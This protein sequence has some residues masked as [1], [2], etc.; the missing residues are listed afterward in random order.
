MPKLRNL[1]VPLVVLCGLI[2]V[3][4]WAVVELDDRGRATQY[5]KAQGQLDTLVTF[6]LRR[7]GR[8]VKLAYGVW[9]GIESIRAEADLSDDP[10]ALFIAQSEPFIRRFMSVFPSVEQ[11]QIADM[12]GDPMLNIFLDAN[13][14][15]RIENTF[16]EPLEPAFLTK[17]I[18]AGVNDT[19]IEGIRARALPSHPDAVFS[20]VLRI[21]AVV[22]DSNQK[23]AAIFIMTFLDEPT[24][25]ALARDISTETEIYITRMNG[26]ML[27]GGARFKDLEFADELGLERKGF[28]ELYPT[29]WRA[30]E[31]SPMGYI[32]TDDGRYAWESHLSPRYVEG[33][34][35]LGYPK[36]SPEGVLIQFMPNDYINKLSVLKNDAV[37]LLLALVCAIYILSTWAFLRLEKAREKAVDAQTQLE[38]ET[39]KRIRLLSVVSH[40]I[41]TP[42]ASMAM[43][44]ERGHPLGQADKENLARL[45]THQLRLL[46]DLRLFAD[47]KAHQPS[48]PVPVRIDEIIDN[49]LLQSQAIVCTSGIVIHNSSKNASPPIIMLDDYRVCTIISNLIRHAC[50]HSNGMNL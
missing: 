34:D 37:L 5:A 10:N 44:L 3:T 27:Y 50:I 15:V 23:A 40:E 24:P 16:L 48:T 19:Y 38:N 9:P 31:S 45:N 8:P 42:A 28:P 36:S 11:V 39:D 4:A 26:E 1:A 2:I 47:P 20:R 14:T 18:E 25:F 22:R 6:T 30:I 41:R 49:A 12:N 33:L 46:D 21:G 43:I 29:V 7:F 17:V 32:D 35:K 13:E